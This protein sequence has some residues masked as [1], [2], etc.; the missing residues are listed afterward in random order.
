MVTVNISIITP[1]I[2]NILLGVCWASYICK[3]VFSTEFGEI[4][5]II[6]S[7]IFSAP[8]LHFSLS[9][10]YRSLD[11]VP[12]V[13]EALSF[14]ISISFSSLLYWLDNFY[15]FVLNPENL[16]LQTSSEIL[17]LLLSASS[18]FSFQL[19]NISVLEFSLE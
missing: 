18:N 8:F 19:L 12:H 5:A 6:S 3:L 17:N 7:N 4:G 10:L 15:W 16:N 13:A 11:I 1:E 9:L 14:L 2:E